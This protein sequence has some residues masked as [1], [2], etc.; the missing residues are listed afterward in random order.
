MAHMD[1]IHDLGG[2]Q[3][4]GPIPVKTGDAPFTH[5]WERRMWGLA[6]A[7]I[8]HDITIDWFRHGIERMV[9]ADYL[10]FAYFNKWATNYLM[11]II[12]NGAVT[13]D[14][15]LSGHVDKP[16]TAAGPLSLA[17]VLEKNRD[18][19][20]SFALDTG[21]APAYAT[22]D[23]VTTRSHG[24][25]GHSRLPAYARGATGT[26]NTWHGAHALPDQGAKGIHKGDHLYTVEFAATD[27]WGER[28]NARDTV[29]LEL[30]ESYFVR[31]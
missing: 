1:T 18:G 5:D 15:A 30:W 31:P 3:G 29:T 17:E 10:T 21:T 16:D 4:F 20:A 6:R 24:T 12:D 8:A 2:K 23:A 22:G 28:A 26:I 7:G 14:E 19:H 27:L 13:M 9:P 11:L 25:A